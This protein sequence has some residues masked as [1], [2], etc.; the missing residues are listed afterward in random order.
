MVYRITSEIGYF[1]SALS[2][3]H[4]LKGSYRAELAADV[5]S[6]TE[7]IV[8][9]SFSILHRDG[10]AAYPHAGLA[11]YALVPVDGKRR[12]MLDVLKQCARAP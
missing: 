9:R 6:D 11:A 7:C 3:D 1:K 5:T 2:A 4:S 10:R 12:V 8:D